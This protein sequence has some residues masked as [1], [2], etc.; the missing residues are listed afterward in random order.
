M[1]D[2]FRETTDQSR[3]LFLA[4]PSGAAGPPGPQE[5]ALF[6]MERRFALLDLEAKAY[7]SQDD[8]KTSGLASN[9]RS[10]CL[11]LLSS[12]DYSSVTPDPTPGFEE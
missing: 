8:Q 1:K 10:S 2:V 12:W 4:N 5:L 7:F 3:S 9:S 11:H 6:S